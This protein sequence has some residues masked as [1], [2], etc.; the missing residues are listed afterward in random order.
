MTYSARD[1]GNYIQI[2]DARTG[3]PWFSVT[4]SGRR[5]NT[6]FING[7]TLSVVYDNGVTEIWDCERRCRVR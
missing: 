3:A 1:M 4:Y 5:L 7:S 2:F 6:Y